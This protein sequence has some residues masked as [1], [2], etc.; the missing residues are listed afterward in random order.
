MLQSI[1]K[2]LEELQK[3]ILGKREQIEWL[4]AGMLG[5][6]HLLIEDVPGTGKTTLAKA[7]AR[8][9]G[10]DF[11]RIQ[12]TPDLLPAD[13]T[14]GAVYS[15]QS[16]QFE[17]RLG[18]VMTQILLADEI[19]RASPR[20]QSALLEAMEEK[21][22]SL[23]GKAWELPAFFMV[24]ATQNPV[25][26]HGVFPLPEAQMD[27]FL[28]R[29]ELGYPDAET[30]QNILYAYQQTPRLDQLQ[31]VLQPEQVVTM[32]HEVRAVHVDAAL[33]HYVVQLIQ[34]TRSRQ[35]LRLPASPRAGM[36]LFRMAQVRAWMQG[37][38]H[39]NPEDVQSCVIPVLAHR[40]FPMDGR[41][42]ASTQPIL[43]ELLTSIPV[44]R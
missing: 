41:G 37:R 8:V 1:Q 26:F 6:G 20:T 10:A 34:A 25:E 36:A 15:S 31:Q 11:Q 14:G 24:L 3:V 30:E 33:G 19:N 29:L 9:T 27:R 16:G 21:Q 4:V 12:F 28:L 44:P 23:E 42:V 13:V 40:I 39:V 2:T 17:I 5:G 38:D 22:V 43:Q 18:P 7:L 32:Q 35:D